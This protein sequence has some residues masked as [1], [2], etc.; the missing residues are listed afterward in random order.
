MM[1]NENSIVKQSNDI[2]KNEA[3]DLVH[4]MYAPET[5]KTEY[6]VFRQLA[7]SLGADP[8]KKEIFTTIYSKNDPVKRKMSIVLSRDFYRRK[9][10]EQPDYNGHRIDAVY[11]NDKFTVINGK[12]NHEWKV[13]KRG[14]LVGAYAIGNRKQISNEFS[15]YVSV[16]E[17][18]KKNSYG[19]AESLWKD[20]PETMIKKVAEAQLFRQMY[21]GLYGSVY[22]ED[23][24]VLIDSDIKELSEKSVYDEEIPEA[25]VEK[26][27]EPEKKKTEKKND[28]FNQ[29]NK[30]DTGD[31]KDKITNFL[32]AE[33]DDPENREKFLSDITG[34]AEKDKE[35]KKL[36]GKIIPGKTNPDQL[37]ARHAE[38][39]WGKIK[40]QFNLD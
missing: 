11:E 27:S 8:R 33:F 31:A 16:E 7:Q 34:F 37:T 21:T 2:W 29:E 15:I 35:T 14:V 1:G 32:F 3:F 6:L 30:N 25:K 4:E 38:V 19:K 24:Q 17:Y 39:T 20:K 28:L 40:T 36:T 9:A 23:E 26:K 5:N 18:L 13:T 12:Y 22:S 10:Q